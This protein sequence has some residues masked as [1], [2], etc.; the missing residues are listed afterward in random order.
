MSKLPRN[1]KGKQLI[2]ALK[3]LGFKQ[4]SAKGS[5]IRLSHPDGRWTQVAIHPKPIPIGTLQIIAEIRGVLR[6]KFQYTLSKLDLM[7]ELLSAIC[8]IV[9]PKMRINIIKKDPDDDKILECDY[10]GKADLIVSGD[11]HLLQLKNFKGIEIVTAREFL[12]RYIF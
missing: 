6:V 12:D 5:H 7:E 10:E 1:I 9:E 4:E 11:K 8:E 3:K 2:R